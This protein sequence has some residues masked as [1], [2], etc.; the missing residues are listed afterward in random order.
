MP[1]EGG[2]CAAAKEED[3]A[4]ALLAALL[5]SWSRP[6]DTVRSQRWRRSPSTRGAALQQRTSRLD[7]RFAKSGEEPPCPIVHLCS[8]RMRYVP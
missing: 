8:L 3:P 6:A 7:S 4:M 1:R 5:S 2:R